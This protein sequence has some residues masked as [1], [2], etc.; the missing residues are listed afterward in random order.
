MPVSMS[1]SL[2]PTQPAGRVARE[3]RRAGAA[4][5]KAGTDTGNKVDKG[6]KKAV[7]EHPLVQEIIAHFGDVRY[8]DHGRR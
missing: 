6:D 4:K 7:M 1:M 8:V 5:K 2:L 3:T